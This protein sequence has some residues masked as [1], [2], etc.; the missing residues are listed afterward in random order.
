MFGDQSYVLSTLSI[1]SSSTIPPPLAFLFTPLVSFSFTP[2]LERYF[3]NFI[4]LEADT[5]RQRD[6]RSDFNEDLIIDIF[7]FFSLP[8]SLDEFTV[9]IYGASSSSLNGII[10][11]EECF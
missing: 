7:F 4:Y 9:G 10:S 2:M 3:D 8:L 6:Q 5:L 11:R 1:P